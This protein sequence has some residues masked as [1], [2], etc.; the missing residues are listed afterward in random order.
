[1][2]YPDLSVWL[3]AN[4][5]ADQGLVIVACIALSFLFVFLD[6]QAMLPKAAKYAR[7]TITAIYIGAL[8]FLFAVIALSGN[9]H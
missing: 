2:N 1:M 7:L 9:L 6:I 8:W 4:Q 5:N 3:K